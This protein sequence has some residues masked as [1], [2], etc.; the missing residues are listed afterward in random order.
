VQAAQVLA[1]RTEALSKVYGT[2]AT[3]VVALDS[4]TVGFPRSEYTAIMGPSGSG[5]S[6]LMHCLAGLD[7]ATSG[8]VAIGDVELTGLDD[9]QLTRLRR[10]AVGFIFQAYNL[11]PMLT[12]L[13]NITLP[14]DIAG[15]RPDQS[16]LDTVVDTVGLRDRLDTSPASSRAGSSSGLPAPGRWPAGRR[17]SSPT[18]PPATW[19]P[20]RAPRCSASCAARSRTWDRRSSWSPTIRAQR[21]TPTGSCSSPTDASSTRCPTPPPSPCWSG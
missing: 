13:E 2:G 3:R 18:S 8:S 9:K 20:A 12:A 15:R 1:A 10:D 4:V 19:T 7:T 5:K 6:T 16:W 17:S 21:R 14:M 11:L